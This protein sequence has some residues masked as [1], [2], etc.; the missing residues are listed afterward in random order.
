MPK[1]D[2]PAVPYVEEPGGLKLLGLPGL[3][4]FEEAAAGLAMLLRAHARTRQDGQT[5]S[6]VPSN[7][8]GV[9]QLIAVTDTGRMFG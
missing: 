1:D 5:L 8:D 3:S 4:A 6:F 7:H 9:T 2:N